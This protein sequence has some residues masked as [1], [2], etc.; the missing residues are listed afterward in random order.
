MDWVHSTRRALPTRT[1]PANHVTLLNSLL[2]TFQ[3]R[4]HSLPSLSLTP[5]W[6][7]L[8]PGKV[9]VLAR[10]CPANGYAATA[11]AA[12]MYWFADQTEAVSDRD[13]LPCYTVHPAYTTSV[14]I[15]L[16]WLG[17]TVAQHSTGSKNSFV[18]VLHFLGISLSMFGSFRTWKYCFKDQLNLGL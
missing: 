14:L 12:L 16:V 3:I 10:T 18:C 2:T 4:L 13:R 7:R 1:S 8:E 5:V 6:S 11:V 15:C 17:P 9:R